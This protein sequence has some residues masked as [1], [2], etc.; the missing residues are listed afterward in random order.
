[1]T[2]VLLTGCGEAQPPGSGDPDTKF[3]EPR[4]AKTYADSDLHRRFHRAVEEYQ[5][6]QWSTW[7]FGENISQCF[8]SNSASMTEDTKETVIEYGIEKAFEK[9]SGAHMERL[10]KVWNLCESLTMSSSVSY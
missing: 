6:S 8:I 2:I 9:L 4:S 3:S 5:K 10:S 7:E 1:M